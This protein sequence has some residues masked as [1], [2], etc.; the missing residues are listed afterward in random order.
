MKRP[1][2]FAAEEIRILYSAHGLRVIKANVVRLS[3]ALVL[4]SQLLMALIYF[5]YGCGVLS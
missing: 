1:A 4:L 5:G 2:F 3:S